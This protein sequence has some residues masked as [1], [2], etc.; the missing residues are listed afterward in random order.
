MSQLPPPHPPP[1][2]QPPSPT[3]R[4]PKSQKMHLKYAISPSGAVFPATSMPA[5]TREFLLLAAASIFI[6]IILQPAAAALSLTSRYELSSPATSVSRLI[7]GVHLMSLEQDP[8]ATDLVHF[9]PWLLSL[10]GLFLRLSLPS[11]PHLGLLILHALADAAVVSSINFIHFALGSGPLPVVTAVKL[12][13]SPLAVLSCLALTSSSV[14]H[15]ILFG[16]VAL[17]SAVQIPIAVSSFLLAAAFSMD[18]RAAAVLPVLI[19]M[20]SRVSPPLPAAS[21]S[22]NVLRG[23]LFASTFVISYALLLV[24]DVAILAPPALSGDA[25]YFSRLHSGAL[26]IWHAV[27]LHDAQVRELVPTI[28]TAWYMMME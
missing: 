6:R 22:A 17:A 7:E 16:S 2:P 19:A 26:T 5:F 18:F 12:C 23:F 28:G 1:P 14:Y 24:A 21:T 25:S 13:F 3:P 20:R 8:Y 15:A 9:P 10:S 4:D 27:P 11:V